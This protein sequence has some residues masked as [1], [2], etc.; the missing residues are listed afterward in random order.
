MR[1]TVAP[2]AAAIFGQAD[3][4]VVLAHLGAG[5]VVVGHADGLLVT[6]GAGVPARIGPIDHQ[7]IARIS[8]GTVLVGVRLAV[9]SAVNTPVFICLGYAIT[10]LAYLQIR[11]VRVGLAA[12]PADSRYADLISGT[13]G[14]SGAGC[15]TNPVFTAP[16]FRAV[17]V[18]Q[19]G[20][21]SGR[22]GITTGDKQ[23]DCQADQPTC[24]MCPCRIALMLMHA[25]AP[26][27]KTNSWSPPIITHFL[28]DCGR[29]TALLS[30]PRT[31]LAVRR[32]TT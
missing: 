17:G 14:G 31:F 28:K 23:D 10:V 21:R 22:L 29:L 30:C 26:F 16:A 7:V 25:A 4:L 5:A 15:I 20:V 8:P 27:G 18:L 9:G 12:G 13:F 2:P 24:P 3:A 11:T 6:I 1:A 19:T 32:I